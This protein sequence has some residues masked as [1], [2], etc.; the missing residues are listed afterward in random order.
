M[1]TLEIAPLKDKTLTVT[2]IEK[3]FDEPFWLDEESQTVDLS[4]LS[5]LKPSIAF[6]SSLEK[7]IESS[8]P[9]YVTEEQGRRTY[10]EMFE[11]NPVAALCRKHAIPFIAVDIDENAREYLRSV[12]S[13]KKSTLSQIL[14]ALEELSKEGDSENVAS[15]RDFLIAYGQCLQDEVAEAELEICF[16]IREK[17][18]VMG[19]LDQARGI[20]KK[21]VSCIHVCSPRHTSGVKRLLESMSVNVFVI[22]LSKKLVST[23]AHVQDLSALLES[24]QIQVRPVV[25]M[26]EEQPYLLFFLCTDNRA[27]SF[28]ISMAYDAGFNAVIPYDNVGVADAKAIV[29]DAI[30]SRDPKGIRRTCF[31]IGG[32]DMEKAE[33]VFKVVCETMF[34]PFKT[35]VVIDP[36]GAYTTAAAMIAKV[37]EGISQSNLGDLRDKTCAILGTGAVGRTAAILLSRLGCK[38][39]ILSLNPGRL[40]GQEYVESLAKM[41]FEKYGANVEGLYAPTPVEKVKA[42]EKADVVFCT[43]AAG[44][45]VIDKEML[46]QIHR[47]KVIADINAVKPLGVEGIKL[48]DDM[49]EISPG[50]YAIGALTIGRLKYR[51]EQDILKEAR[52]TG[53]GTY[54][55]GFA[56][57]LARKLLRAETLNAKLSLTLT[58]PARRRYP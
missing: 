58:Y 39:T 44:V 38:T 1:K 36:A 35:S 32:K 47:I 52:K 28:D 14:G 41:L 54:S 12:I 55:Y 9:D 15:Q 56:I 50:I 26:S 30:F 2:I 17:W 37:E 29:Q 22:Q 24:V 7:L 49:R 31:F 45:R 5:I 4:R 27:S 57:Q 19:I 8:T 21:E 34:P 42:I 51:L 33:E 46:D 23:K 11:E 3:E 25:R 13:N 18:I 48:D 20:E 53:D 16:S 40:D 10:K 43:A 6:I